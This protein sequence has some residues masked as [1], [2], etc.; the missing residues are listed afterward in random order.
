M[1]RKINRR[2]PEY[3]VWHKEGR[4][5]WLDTAAGQTVTITNLRKVITNKDIIIN[6]LK[7][8]EKVFGTGFRKFIWITISSSIIW[9]IYFIIN[10]F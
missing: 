9:N 6:A 4:K 3:I 5:I 10:S 1:G 2:T 7:A 8:R